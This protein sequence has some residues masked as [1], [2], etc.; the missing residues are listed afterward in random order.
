MNWIIS[1]CLP[2]GCLSLSFRDNKDTFKMATPL[3][4]RPPVLSLLLLLTMVQINPHMSR[5]RASGGLDGCAQIRIAQKMAAAYGSSSSWSKGL[6]GRARAS[7]GGVEQG[8]NQKLTLP[9]LAWAFS[10]VVSPPKLILVAHL[11]WKSLSEKGFKRSEEGQKESGE[12][13]SLWLAK[14]RYSLSQLPR[15]NTHR[16]WER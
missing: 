4:L 15:K 8:S 12:W 2:E 14:F 1:N 11:L 6:Q 3:T 5:P 13:N 10:C 7:K 16:N 9:F